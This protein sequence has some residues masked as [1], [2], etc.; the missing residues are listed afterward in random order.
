MLAMTDIG[1]IYF[2][3]PLMVRVNVGPAA[4]TGVLSSSVNARLP[5]QLL[6]VSFGGCERPL[7]RKW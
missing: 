2:L 3:P 5:W 1:E 6:K 4:C 7:T